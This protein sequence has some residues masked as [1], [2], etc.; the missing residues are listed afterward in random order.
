MSQ[1]E[2][3]LSQNR[4][5]IAKPI[6]IEG[7]VAYVPLTKGYEAVIDAA[8]VPLIESWYWTANV[9]NGRAYATRWECENGQPR[10]VY[11]HK[12]ILGVGQDTEGD[13]KDGNPLNNRRRNLRPATHAQNTQ[14]RKVPCHNK[15]GIKGVRK[16][17]N[18]FRAK[19]THNG[20]VYRLGYFATPEEAAAAY[21]GAARVLF[22]EFARR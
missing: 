1:A 3:V 6:R 8:D 21:T 4:K 11:M 9:S 13:H 19:I 12:I 22:G 17:G 5:R 14:N 10:R 18:R 16:K 2:P 20:T 15:T 7:D